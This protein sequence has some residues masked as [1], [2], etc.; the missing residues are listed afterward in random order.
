M[1]DSIIKKISPWLLCKETQERKSR[2]ERPIKKAAVE[3][4]VRDN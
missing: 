3:I 4:K 1:I 2:T